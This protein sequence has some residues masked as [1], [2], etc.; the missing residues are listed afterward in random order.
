MP[1]HGLYAF[2]DEQG[3]GQEYGRSRYLP[4]YWLTASAS[5]ALS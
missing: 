5:S 1:A 2:N 3:E 4:Q